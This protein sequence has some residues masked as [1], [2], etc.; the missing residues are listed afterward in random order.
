MPRPK[1]HPSQR[2]R[3]AEACNFCRMS[4]K[5]CSATVPCT[6]CQRRGIGHTCYLT[7]SPRASRSTAH[8]VQAS[9]GDGSPATDALSAGRRASGAE[10]V[11]PPDDSARCWVPPEPVIPLDPDTYQPI[12]PSDSR[13]AATD[14]NNMESDTSPLLHTAQRESRALGRESHARMLL[15]LRGERGKPGVLSFVRDTVA[16]QIGPSQFSHNDRSE[17]MLENEPAINGSNVA[18]PGL[19]ELDEDQRSSYI[20]LFHA[21]TGGFLDLFSREEL[22]Q[23]SSVP[24]PELSEYR[25]RHIEAVA[26]AAIAIGSQCKSSLESQQTSQAYFRHAQRKAFSGMLEDPNIDIVRVFLLMAYYMLGSCRRNS[27]FMYLGIASRAA[28]SLGLHSKDTYDDNSAHRNN[29]PAATSGLRAEVDESHISALANHEEEDTAALFAVYGIL[30]ITTDVV[31]N[32]YKKKRPSVA[33]IERAFAR[34]EDWSRAI[35]KSMRARPDPTLRDTANRQDV[36]K[37]HISCLY[38]FAVTL[39]SRPIL[40]SQLTSQSNASSITL[41]PLASACLDAAVFLVQ[42]CTDAK[43]SDNL[44]GSL[45]IIKALVFAAGLILGFDMFAKRELDFEIESAFAGAREILDFIAEQSSQAAHYAEILGLLSSAIAEQRR[46]TASQGRS[47][48]V[49]RL[50]SSSGDDAT[51]QGDD[52]SFRPSEGHWLLGQPPTLSAELESDFIEGLDVL[53]LSQWDNF[54][55]NSPRSFAN[56]G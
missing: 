27:A 14:T 24:S 13:A 26:S 4:K 28:V 34:I 33:L 46:K 41:S 8:R 31:E 15:N 7:H 55:F 45:C 32:L 49:S 40:I 10:T 6:A 39:V 44:F 52:V 3:A 20:D 29:R 42:T 12:S 16:A 50:F 23:L 38:Y 9:L 25:Y 2:K 36:Y 1:V 54:P 5:K 11:W 35:P 51:A 21:A 22:K 17:T 19:I 53:D 18:T 37:L 43:K 48:L 30:S 47:K 56:E